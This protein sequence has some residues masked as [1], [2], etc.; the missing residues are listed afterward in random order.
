M[1]DTLGTLLAS[2]PTDQQEIRSL[3]FV[4]LLGIVSLVL[5]LLFAILVLTILRY[6]RRT[7][8]RAKQK[9]ARD[10]R[11]VPPPDPWRIAGRRAEAEGEG[12]EPTDPLPG[13]GPNG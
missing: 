11:V 12:D 2:A 13:G 9:R 8:D 3:T 7:G 1:F 6:V 5:V 4:T 10:D